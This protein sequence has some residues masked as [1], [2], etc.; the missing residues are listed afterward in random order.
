MKGAGASVVSMSVPV[1]KSATYVDVEVSLNATSTSVT[2]GAWEVVVTAIKG[3]DAAVVSMTVPD[4]EST[5]G[6]DV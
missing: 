1:D 3:A 2:P 4:D 6:F 5:I